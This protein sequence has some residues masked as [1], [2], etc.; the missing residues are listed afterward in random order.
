VNVRQW[1]SASAVAAGIVLGQ[2]TP[3]LWADTKVEYTFGSLRPLAAEEAKTKT[4][5]WLKSTGKP[6]DAT[7]L[8]KIWKAEGTSVL[9]KTLASLELGSDDAKT[10]LAAARNSAEVAPKEIPAILKDE[11]QNAFLRAN[12][13]LGFAKGL[14][15]GRV[16]EESLEALKLIAPDQTVDPSAY[17]FHR[18]VAEHAL[19]KREEA[20]KSIVKLLDD[21]SESPDRY[22]MLATIMFIDMGSWKK[23]EKDL[24][25]IRRLM[26]NSERRLSQARPGKTTQ[27]I[28]KKIVFRLDELIKEKE[29]QCKG[30]QC[31]GGACPN[32][33]AGNTPGAGSIRPNSAAPD[34]TVKNASGEGKVDEKK[35]REY[36]EKWGTMPEK[37]RA[38]AIAEITKDL[39]ARYRQVIEDYFKSLSNTTAKP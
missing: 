9:E 35:L 16:Y 7:E 28:Q 19:M 25:N 23:D 13:T 10:I 27:E 8:A 37:E 20:L 30:G 24:A 15:N 12:L 1:L 3:T 38:K 21:V 26:D 33:G 18:A 36:S 29:N 32:G 6:F 5:T 17:F 14:T 11:K 4:E 31:N 39:P 34:S 22:K 2:A